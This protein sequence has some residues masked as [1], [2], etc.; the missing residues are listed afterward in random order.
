MGDRIPPRSPL[1]TGP[2]PGPAR[3]ASGPATPAAP[4]ATGPV[5]TPSADGFGVVPG[6]PSGGS[7]NST[8][9]DVLLDLGSTRVVHGDDPGDF[10]CEHMFYAGQRAAEQS[11]TVAK[12]PQ[13][14]RLVGFLHV[15]WDGFTSK[16]FVDGAYAQKDRH[17]LTRQV[18]G[19]AL[20]GYFV[21]AKAAAGPGPVHMMVTGYGP[22][23][24][25]RDNPTGDFVRHAENIDAAMQ[26]AFGADLLTPTGQD[27]ADSGLPA[28]TYRR[29]Y[30]VKDGGQTREV[31]VQAQW[32][33]VTDDAIDGQ[34]GRSVQ[35]SIAQFGAHAVVSMG[36]H[37]GK[38]YLAEHHA[39][40]GGLRHEAGRL[41]HDYSR[42]PQHNLAD[43][44]ALPRA[45]LQGDKL[46][47]SLSVTDLRTG[48]GPR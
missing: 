35:K 32:F 38:E 9:P 23:S 4:A 14:E 12:N 18:I 44:Y 3:S 36:V 43:N 15:P 33:P 39:D 11:A 28:D 2:R 17:A 1:T 30:K 8:L 21:D 42:Q 19:A 16:T 27:R 26:H 24:S 41:V 10:Y 34:H 45:I 37:S 47:R 46:R 40:D 13:G 29:V 5:D 6:T 20:R 48:G 31:V 7:H 25:A 22:F